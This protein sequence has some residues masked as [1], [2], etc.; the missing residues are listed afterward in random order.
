MDL[1]FQTDIEAKIFR[2]ERTFPQQNAVALT[3]EQG[4]QN[5]SQK[6][7]NWRQNN[8]EKLQE[9]NSLLDKSVSICTSSVTNWVR[10]N[11]KE[12]LQKLKT[13]FRQCRSAVFFFQQN[14]SIDRRVRKK[15]WKKTHPG[16]FCRT[17]WHPRWHVCNNRKEKREKR[18][19]PF[20]L[21]FYL[22]LFYPSSPAEIPVIRTCQIVL[23]MTGRASMRPVRW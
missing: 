5:K 17:F 7:C 23:E 10:F 18:L 19:I 11:S 15:G 9:N 1:H 16:I 20:L 2:E 8:R 22:P 6:F 13:N 12:I 21:C 3:E 14:G 4:A